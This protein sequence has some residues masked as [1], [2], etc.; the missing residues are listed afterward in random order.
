MS[1]IV[2]ASTST[3]TTTNGVAA[4]ALRRPPAGRGLVGREKLLAFAVAA[5]AVVVAAVAVATLAVVVVDP[6]QRQQQ[7]QREQIFAVSQD[8][9]LLERLVRNRV[10]ELLLLSR[11]EETKKKDD[12]SSFS[13]SSK[14]LLPR[15]VGRDGY[16]DN[17]D[18]DDDVLFRMSSQDGGGGDDGD[19]AI[20]SSSRSL[21]SGS[22]R[23][24]KGRKGRRTRTLSSS[25]SSQ[26][27]TT[28]N[29]SP[30]RQPLHQRQR[31]SQRTTTRRRRTTSAAAS[32][33]SSSHQQQASQ[34]RQQQRALE[35]IVQRMRS[36]IRDLQEAA[37]SAASKIDA[38]EGELQKQNKQKEQSNAAPTGSSSTSQVATAVRSANIRSEKKKK[39][40]V[41]AQQQATKQN[42]K[43]TRSSSVA[44][45]RK[46]IALTR[47][48]NA[49]R[50][51]VKSLDAELDEV[52]A[53]RIDPMERCL[54]SIATVRRDSAA[55]SQVLAS[56]TQL[57]PPPPKAAGMPIMAPITAYH[58][59]GAGNFPA[60]Q[61]ERPIYKHVDRN[62]DDFWNYL[63][64]ELLLSR[65]NLVLLHGR[66]CYDADPPSGA[67]DDS[68]PGNLCPRLLRHFVDAV[69]RSDGA[70]G[71]LKVGM[72][73]ATGSKPELAGVSR[74]D[75]S[76]PGNW[77]YFWDHNIR[78][79]FD[80]IP[81]DWWCVLVFCFAFA[82]YSVLGAYVSVCA[83]GART[84]RSHYP[85]F[86]F[87]SGT[88]CWES[89]SSHS[90]TS[91]IPIS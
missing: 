23:K 63:V 30:F 45:T 61:F 38:L 51:D 4:A 16:R 35:T 36:E 12:F 75:L 47:N 17:D 25:Q 33:S 55:V 67:V 84:I 44:N 50:S 6:K 15:L 88:C 1:S 20:F 41:S 5:A 53:D 59:T 72:F 87:C 14:R 60:D 52:V 26:S 49:I 9:A 71:V 83:R 80:T 56:D 42:K 3:S 76:V 66:G 73:D 29:D 70:E 85:I 2:P 89:P 54:N 58:W 37:R 40:A 78:I 10:D 46:I 18:D 79:W 57:V 8:N 24:R 68:G 48:V 19:E 43:K 65:S 21:T 11:L 27:G 77:K 28:G 7:Q 62:H 31:Q 90:G 81:K 69:R 22:G 82:A 39:T 86:F 91:G 74:L 32:S 64:D 34:Q 13:F